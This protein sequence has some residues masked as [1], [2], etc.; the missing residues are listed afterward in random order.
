MIKEKPILF[1]GPMVRAILEGKKTQTR[2][3]MKPQ[4]ES[5]GENGWKWDGHAPNS[6]YGAYASTH[7]DPISLNIFVGSSNP[8][9]QRGDRL[10]VRETFTIESNFNVDGMK[11]YPPPFKDGRPAKTTSCPEYG[12]YWEQCHY[13]ATDPEPELS[14]E[15]MDG[16]GCRWKPSIHMPRWASR[17]NLEI[18]DIRVERVQD[19][20][21]QD[22]KAEG[23]QKV[24]A[25]I[26]FTK[27]FKE[28]WDE[29]NGK[30]RANGIDI[31]WEAN[32]WVWVVTFKK[33][34]LC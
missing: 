24:M 15:D 22:A 34:E 7:Q 10:W 27:N 29:I 21:E 16:P 8:Y 28:L 11:E 32:P 6:P 25:F 14:Y 23:V 33:E 17:I 5:F 1:S 12:E 2:R 3:V 9:G 26:G 4:V 31:S 19:I 13:R 30:P 18:T 20:S